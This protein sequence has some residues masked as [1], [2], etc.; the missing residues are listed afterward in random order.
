VTS[1]YLVFQSGPARNQ[2]N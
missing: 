1:V 2:I